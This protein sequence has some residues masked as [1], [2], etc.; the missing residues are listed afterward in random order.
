MI[1]DVINEMLNA[2]II[3]RSK[4]PRSFPF[5]I[6]DKK[7]GSKIFCLDFRAL[8]KITKSNSYP[9]PVI[10]DILALFVGEQN[11]LHL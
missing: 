9:L 2:K 8:N 5:V 6:V 4:S 10:Y 1:D 11:L 7:Y 3:Q